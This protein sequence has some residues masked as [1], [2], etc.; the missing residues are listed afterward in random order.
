VRARGWGRV[1]VG[2]S[3]GVLLGAFVSCQSTPE[4]YGEALVVL[5]TEARVPRD[6]ARVRVDSYDEKG[7]WFDSRD[8]GAPTSYDWPVSF[9]VVNEDLSNDKVVNLRIRAYPDGRLRDY[10]GNAYSAPMPWTEPVV[11]TSLSGLCSSPPL[12]ALGSSITQRRGAHAFT[13][14]VPTASSPPDCSQPTLSGSVAA[15]VVI[16]TAD[17]YRFE[18]V[19]AVPDGSVGQIGGDTTLAVR[20]ACADPTTQ[21]ACNDDI[22]P[23]A[24][25]RLSRVTVQLQPGTYFLVTG[26]ADPAP[27]DLTLRGDHAAQWDADLPSAYTASTAPLPQP[28]LVVG[29]ADLTPLVEP[30]P[31]V[32]I[33]RLVTIRLHPGQRGTADVQLRGACL[34]TAADVPAGTSCADTAGQ[35]VPTTE[36]PLVDGLSRS[37]SLALG[38]WPVAPPSCAISPRAGSVSAGG[39]ALYDEEVCVQG[40]AFTLGDDLGLQSGVYQSSP[41]RDYLMSSFLLDKYEYTVGRY[42]QALRAG[43]VPPDSGPIANNAPLSESAGGC[44]W[45][46]GATPDEPASGI[47]RED[48]PLNCVSWTTARALCQRESGDLPT[49]AEWEFAATSAGKAFESQYPWG[50]SV[51]DC[52]RIVFYRRPEASNCYPPF[53]PVGVESMPWS[54][55]DATPAGVTGMGGNVDEWVLDAFE[56]Y[57]HPLW[58]GQPMQAPFA[59]E[60]NAPLRS[61]RGSDWS[62]GRTL[63]ATSS[64]R[65]A[66]SPIAAG[67]D[68]G[69][70]CARGGSGG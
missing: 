54:Q 12:L 67:D 42:R 4:P 29:G 28:R 20:T 55:G 31:G 5:S 35:L 39:Q 66:R 18:V 64:V 3:T 23:S 17:T 13:G 45:N 10:A 25:D 2:A 63:Q 27:A 14:V 1:H 6:V 36:L 9:S 61:T 49:E 21:I 58:L 41:E 24:A 56:A 43:F 46:V 19:A 69:F 16:T 65:A 50:D 47:A 32:T 33:D 57:D 60:N 53:G 34:G 7:N 68:L 37:P 48:F 52:S 26:G 40:D 30:E 44:T 8:I 11:Q 22:D 62:Y 59:W 38:S 51:P 15:R 70:R